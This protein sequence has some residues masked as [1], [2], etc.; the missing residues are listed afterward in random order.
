MAN[1]RSIM[2]DD[3]LT[4]G[5]GNL[6]VAGTSFF[7]AGGPFQLAVTGGTSRYRDAAGTFTVRAG[8]EG[9]RDL[10]IIRLVD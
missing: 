8:G 7:E 4:R 1:H 9:P 6:E 3:T 5:S 10:L 2:C